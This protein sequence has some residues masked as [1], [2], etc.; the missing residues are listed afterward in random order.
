MFTSVVC[1]S[2]KR[3]AAYIH[4]SRHYKIHIKNKKV[5]IG[6]IHPVDLQLWR[7]Y[8]LFSSLH[9]STAGQSS[10]A[11]ITS[12]LGLMHPWLVQISRRAGSAAFSGPLTALVWPAAPLRVSCLYGMVASQ[13]SQGHGSHWPRWSSP[14]QWR[15]ARASFRK[16][17]NTILCS[18]CEVGLL[19][20][21][22]I[23]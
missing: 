8:K 6:N 7:S 20:G 14:L 13:G 22:L 23:Y 5:Y 4:L 2:V 9:D 16:S 15:S 3:S 12:T 11:S 17:N 19:P 1:G 10:D 18:L 21:F